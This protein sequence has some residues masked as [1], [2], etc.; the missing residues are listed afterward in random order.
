MYVLSLYRLVKGHII[1]C[2]KYYFIIYIFIIR[3]KLDVIFK[4]DTH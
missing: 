3:Y 1:L 2:M 4:I